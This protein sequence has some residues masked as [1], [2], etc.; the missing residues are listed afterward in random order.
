MTYQ[1]PTSAFRCEYARPVVL[2]ARGGIDGGHLGHAQ[3]AGAAQHEDDDDTV[4]QCHGPARRD[5]DGQRGGDGGPA[6]AN[7]PSRGH[8]LEPR[9]LVACGA[10]LEAELR[11]G[12]VAGVVVF[13]AA[14]ARGRGWTRL[15][16]SQTTSGRHVT[17]YGQM[18][19]GGRT[20]IVGAGG[21]CYVHF[22]RRF[23]SSSVPV[24]FFGRSIVSEII[25]R[26]ES[27]LYQKVYKVYKVGQMVYSG[28]KD[29]HE[30]SAATFNFVC[31]SSTIETSHV[32][33]HRYIRDRQMVAAIL[34][35]K[36][37]SP[38]P[39]TRIDTHLIRS[40]LDKIERRK[41]PVQHQ[42]VVVSR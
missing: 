23:R 32:N 36:H 26:R 35:P 31:L 18:P 37:A 2:S 13:D 33:S 16:I 42:A 29:K 28:G 30:E 25:I 4:Q 11:E 39:T 5:R 27:P 9:E 15:S 8:Q 38:S 20:M 6:I 40:M 22:S 41:R 10:W 19:S 34:L 12:V 7:V 24:D 17:S 3:G 1:S 14:D 21:C